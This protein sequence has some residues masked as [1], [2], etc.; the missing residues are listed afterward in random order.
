MLT[1]FIQ[2]KEEEKR[3]LADWRWTRR[4]S[5]AIRGDVGMKELSDSENL[6]M[7]FPLNGHPRVFSKIVACQQFDRIK[8][9]GR[10]C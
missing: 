9:G 8:D 1:I 5:L 3:E 4:W 7:S 6:R 10:I 2:K